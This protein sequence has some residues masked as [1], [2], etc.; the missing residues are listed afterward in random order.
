[1][2]VEPGDAQDRGAARA[3]LGACARAR[4]IDDPRCAFLEPVV[5]PGPA[6]VRRYLRIRP[7]TGT[8][9]RTWAGNL[10]GIR[11]FLPV[12]AVSAACRGGRAGADLPPGIS[13]HE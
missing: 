13:R 5:R 4:G 12:S 8:W 11:W 9:D 1:M 6:E 7:D 2:R 10:A 3:R